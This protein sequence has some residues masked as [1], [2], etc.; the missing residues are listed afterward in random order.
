[1]RPPSV[2]AT[3]APAN[4]TLPATS[5][6]NEPVVSLTTTFRAMASP[7]LSPIL[8]SPGSDPLDTWSIDSTKTA[9]HK[10][11]CLCTICI[12]IGHVVAAAGYSVSRTSAQSIMVLTTPTPRQSTSASR[13]NAC[14]RCP[15]LTCVPVDRVVV[16]MLSTFGTKRKNLKNSSCTHSERTNEQNR[17]YQ[18]RNTWRCMHTLPPHGLVLR[19]ARCERVLCARWCESVLPV[20]V[21]NAVVLHCDTGECVGLRETVKYVAHQ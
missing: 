21:V 2:M 7:L 6:W 3:G 11:C 18:P 5:S 19:S 17:P 4:H 1:M 14:S 8:A 15:P 12:H 9:A 20:R 10:A 13:P 16:L